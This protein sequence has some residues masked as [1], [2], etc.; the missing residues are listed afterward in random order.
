MTDREKKRQ[1]TI[2][3]RYGSLEAFRE[4]QRQGGRKG[5]KATGDSKRRG[6][7]DYYSRIGKL[8]RRDGDYYSRVG[9]MGK[10]RGSEE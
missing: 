1:E 7:S 10:K 6:D 2:I 4:L 5:G 3:R 9:M 8:S